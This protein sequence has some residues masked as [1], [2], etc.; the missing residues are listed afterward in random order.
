M[1]L[2]VGQKKEDLGPL[3]TII[4]GGIAGVTLWT[5]IF[6]ADV[7]KSRQQVRDNF[8]PYLSLLR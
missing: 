6:P 1:S 3:G 8:F 4:S 7:I 2:F 5:V